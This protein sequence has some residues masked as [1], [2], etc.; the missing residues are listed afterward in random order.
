MKTRFG[1]A[2]IT[3]IIAIA[4]SVTSGEAGDGDHAKHESHAGDDAHAIH[5]GHAD[6]TGGDLDQVALHGGPVTAAEDWHFETVFTT[7]G[8]Q[9]YK[10]SADLAPQMMR[11]TTGSLKLVYENGTSKEIPLVL[12]APNADETTVH[13]CPMHS[14]VVQME[15][16][17]C[18]LCGGMVLFRQDYLFGTVDLSREA[19][20]SFSAMV[21]ISGLGGNKS[22]VSFMAQFTNTITNERKSQ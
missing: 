21:N 14:E 8:V 20:G 10:Y 15:A 6:N 5:E 18:D 7:E 9:I 16:G 2:I 4:F 12:K 11:K 13:F 3:A 1:A 22:D 17:V 19:P